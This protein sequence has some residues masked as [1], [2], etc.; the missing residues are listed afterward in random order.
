[1]QS[2]ASASVWHARKATMKALKTIWR[3]AGVPIWLAVSTC[4]AETAEQPRE[5]LSADTLRILSN[6]ERRA[7]ERTAADRRAADSLNRDGERAY[8]KGDYR[9]ARTA[10]SDSYPNF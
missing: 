1:M 9:A 10:F 7:S 2:R 4:T 8:R 5:P 6:I 3:L